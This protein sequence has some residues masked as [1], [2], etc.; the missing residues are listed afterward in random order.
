MVQRLIK[1]TFFSS[2]RTAISVLG[3]KFELELK[4][5]KL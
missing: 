1:K 5:E 4:K 3:N 2:F